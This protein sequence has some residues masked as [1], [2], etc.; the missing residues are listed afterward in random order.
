[1]TGSITV[2]GY[3][4]NIGIGYQNTNIPLD[5]N[6]TGSNYSDD[7]LGLISEKTL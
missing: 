6:A 2:D 1:M 4:Y 5:R 7:M 3:N